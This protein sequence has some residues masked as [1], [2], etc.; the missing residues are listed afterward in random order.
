[1]RRE[2]FGTFH[3]CSAGKATLHFVKNRSHLLDIRGSGGILTVTVT[4]HDLF[5][6]RFYAASIDDA[7]ESASLH[8]GNKWASIGE[9]W[10]VSRL[11]CSFVPF[12]TLREGHDD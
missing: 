1:L 4:C 7:S 12:L 8:R 10:I 2:R 3:E 11:F 5:D 6:R 9:E